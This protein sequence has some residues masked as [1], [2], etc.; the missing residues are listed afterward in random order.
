MRNGQIIKVFAQLRDLEIFDAEDQLCGIADDVE[1]EGAPGGALRIAAL[2]VGP[3][4]YGA[5]MPR[6]LARGLQVVAG[7]S[8]VRVPWSAVDHVTS[9]IRLNKTARELGL[10]AFERRLQPL[11]RRIPLS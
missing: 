5:R 4:A 10:L 2:L 7:R 1:L 11:L 8:M 3:G 9:R 6:I